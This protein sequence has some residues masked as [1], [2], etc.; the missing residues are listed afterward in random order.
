MKSL[1]IRP[2]HQDAP[3]VRSDAMKLPYF[4]LKVNRKGELLATGGGY[5]DL[6]DESFL[7][8]LINAVHSSSSRT[9][10]LEEYSLRYYRADTPGDQCIVFSDTSNEQLIL[11]NILRNS[12]LIGSACFIVFLGISLLLANWAVRPVDMAWKQ[13]RQFIADASHELKTPLTVILTNAEL[14]QSCDYDAE[15]QARFSSSI[16]TMAQQMRGLVEQLLELARADNAQDSVVFSAVALSRLVLDC[17][18]PFEPMFFEKQLSLSTDIQENIFVSGGEAQLRQVV[19]ILLDN[20]QKYS[21]S[22]GSVAVSLHCLG[23]AHCLLTVSNTGEAIAAEELKN[24][25]KRFYRVDKARSRSGGFGLGLPI[26]ESIVSRH[27]GRIWAESRDGINSFKVELPALAPDKLALP[28][29]T[30]S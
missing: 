20:A 1:A 12:F 16:L 2:L 18:L 27:K 4:I 5:Y 10:V 25:F 3:D 14:L 30:I 8:E 21:S 29:Q 7:E 28:E 26:A 19:E 23:R 11:K 6:S 22:G 13:Q 9:G 15:S 17:T 24:I